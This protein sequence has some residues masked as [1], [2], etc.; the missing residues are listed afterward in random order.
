MATPN[1]LD[2]FNQFM[3]KGQLALASGRLRDAEDQLSRAEKLRPKDPH[4]QL[5][6]AIVDHRLGRSAISAQRIR[7]LLERDPPNAID[8]H[9]VLAEVLMRSNQRGELEQRIRGGGVWSDDPRG[10]LFVARLDAKQDPSAAASRL[11]AIARGSAPTH[12]RRA[13]HLPRAATVPP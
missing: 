8:A 5:Q 7:A 9:M 2:A 12:L 6:R 10:E 11:E 4:C 3:Q 1:P 13:T